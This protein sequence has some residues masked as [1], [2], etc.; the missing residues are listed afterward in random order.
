MQGILVTGGC[1][2]I[3]QHVVS[4]LLSATHTFVRVVDDF[5]HGS[6]QNLEH[7]GPIELA[8]SVP[9]RQPAERLQV[10]CGDIGDRKLAAAACRG[11]GAVIHLAANTGVAQSVADPHLDCVTNVLGTLNY[12]EGARSAGVTRFIFA[13][14]GAVI[15]EVAPPMH[16]RLAARPVSP[17]GASKLAGEAYCSAYAR[18]F[19]LVTVALR[20]GNVYGP[21]SAHK[22]SVVAKFIRHA[23][24]GE[25]L[26]IYGDGGQTRDFIFIDDLVRAIRLAR[27]ASLNGSEVFQIASAKETTVRELASALSAALVA[28]G[29]P[30]PGLDFVSPQAG[31]VFRNFADTTKA[32]ELLGWTAEVDLD[33]GLR[34]T[35]RWAV[36]AR[37]AAGTPAASPKEMA[38][39]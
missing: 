13:S 17:Y 4:D 11:V 22:Q 36:A 14:S 5:S 25:R 33:E 6:V 18:T 15:G 24:A 28:E 8:E 39:Q 9:D 19:K 1:G 38:A 16:E 10:I 26:P 34:K 12:L 35:V 27:T 20:F 30:N 21:G 29:L 37:R 23:F 31:E 2:F 7:L 32:K 3:G